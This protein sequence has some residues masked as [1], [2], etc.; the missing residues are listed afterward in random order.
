MIDLSVVIVS[1]ETRRLL[2]D[3]LRSV[4]SE[5]K[6]PHE[7][8]V[9]DNASTDGSSEMVAERFP[10]VRLVEMEGNAGFARAA[11]VGAA[12]ARGRYICLLNPDTV[13]LD[14]AL[15]RL[16]AFAEENPAAGICGG[17]TLAADGRVD[18]RSCWAQPTL[19][20]LFCFAFGLSTLFRRNRLFDPESMGRWER[21]TVRTVDIVTGCLLLARRDVWEALGGFDERFYMYGEDADLSLRAVAAGHRP[22]ITP[23]AVITHYVGAASQTRADKGRLL[24]AGRITLIYEHWSTRRASV[25]RALILTGIAVRALAFKLMR[26]PSSIRQV[27]RDR[28]IWKDG[29]P[30]PDAEGVR[31]RWHLRPPAET[32]RA[33]P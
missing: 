9:V 3:C 17:R 19:W 16:V 26:R 24:L 12:L 21:D 15:D 29:Y 10:A 23:Q 22:A 28:A 8:I 33:A 18:P 31:D 1:Y 2:D 5:T 20:S 32:S 7:V 14:Q 25:G 30:V 27:W 6:R 13:V 11:N 4:R